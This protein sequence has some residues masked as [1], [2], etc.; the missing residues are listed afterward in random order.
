MKLAVLSDIHGGYVALQACMERALAEQV[1][2]FVF[3]GDYLGELAYP[4]RTMELLYE[5]AERHTC[6]FVK[7]NKED[8]WLRHAKTPEQERCWKEVDSTTGMLYYVYEQ[9]EEKDFAFFRSLT[10]V[11]ELTFEGLPAITIC[12]GSPEHIKQDLL[13]ND[14]VT[15]EILQKSPTDIILCGH[16]HRQRRIYLEKSERP[17]ESATNAERFENI[18]K[19]KRILNPG[20][21]GIPLDSD[22]K[23]QFMILTGENG[24][25]KEEFISLEYDVEKM[26]GELREERLFEKAPGWCRITEKVLRA[27]TPSH[28]KVLKRAMQLCKEA[29]GEC[30]WPDIPEE[31]WDKAIEEMLW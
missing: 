9:L 22:G 24:Q 16:T 31:C 6:Y 27:G 28:G 7:G 4:R 30:N 15:Q 13:P 10:H 2:A 1:D 25:W 29:T 8:Y 18:Y 5:L 17:E 12:H 14:E 21:V 20:S 11:R 3:L 19:R 26:L 23:T